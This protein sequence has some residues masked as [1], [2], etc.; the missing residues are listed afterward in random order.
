MGLAY[1]YLHYV[2]LMN[3]WFSCKIYIYTVHPMGMHRGAFM[4]LDPLLDHRGAEGKIHEDQFTKLKCKRLNKTHRPPR[5]HSS[6]RRVVCRFFWWWCFFFKLTWFS[7]QIEKNHFP[8][9]VVKTKNP[10]KA[11][12]RVLFVGV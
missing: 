2:W 9:I 7:S 4:E 5:F 3:L 12:P 11:T 6:G 1:L 8:N 10:L